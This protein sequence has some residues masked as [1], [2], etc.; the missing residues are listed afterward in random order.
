MNLCYQS[1]D[2]LKT[3]VPCPTLVDKAEPFFLDMA[4]NIS[5]SVLK[6]HG[7]PHLV[8]AIKCASDIKETPFQIRMP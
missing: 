1:Q 6:G 5:V 4:V 2:F 8:H 3:N 7:S